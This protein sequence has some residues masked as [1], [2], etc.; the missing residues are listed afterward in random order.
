[1]V[2]CLD[3][4]LFFLNQTRLENPRTGHIFLW[5]NHLNMGDFPANLVEDDTGSHGGPMG[6]GISKPCF[7]HSRNSPEVDSH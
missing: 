5:E 3:I 6:L 7:F 1:M 4:Y 2:I